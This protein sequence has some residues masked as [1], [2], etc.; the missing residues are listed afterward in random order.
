MGTLSEYLIRSSVWLT[1]FGLIYFLFLRDER[2]F[3]LNRIFLLTG[4][5]AS[6]CFPLIRVHYT[7]VIPIPVFETAAVSGSQPAIVPVSTEQHHEPN[8]L[9]CLYLSGILYLIFRLLKQTIRVVRVIRKSG[10]VLFNH[11]R[12]VR[13]DCYPAPFSFFKYVFVNPSV[14][15][16]EI[17]EIVHHE[18]EHIRQR[19]WIDLVLYELICALQWFNPAVWLYGRFIRQNHEYLADKSALKRSQDPGKYRA[20]LLN[21]MFGAPVIQLANSFCYSLNKKRFTMMKQTTISSPVRKLRLLWI[22]PLIAGIFYA[23]ATPEYQVVQAEETTGTQNIPKKVSNADPSFP[24]D[25]TL[26]SDR[27]IHKDD[28]INDR[29]RKEPSKI[30][31]AEEKQAN[32]STKKIVQGRVID[33]YGNPLEGVSV[34]VSRTNMTKTDADGNFELDMTDDDPVSFSHAGLR[35]TWRVMP[36]FEKSTTVKMK[37]EIQYLAVHVGM[38]VLRKSL[39]VTGDNSNN[40]AGEDKNEKIYAAVEQMPEFPGGVEALRRFIAK[41]IRYPKIAA[42]DRAQGQV[43]VSFVVNREGNIWNVKVDKS[44]H[45]ALDQEAIRVIYSLPQWKPGIHHE[46]PV[47]VAYKIPIS[48]SYEEIHK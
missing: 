10:S 37:S 41:G 5:I 1:G 18:Q 2:Y 9:F 47:N 16:A 43:F 30:K 14:S 8:L 44:V 42:E 35:T 39:A 36:D 6:V 12:L 22:L 4:M 46:K 13:A 34:V 19:H 7:Q 33:E 24:A 28:K 27:I 32:Q 40:N 11:I 38:T 31:R 25:D 29:E 48:F 15:E 17:S 3:T 45:P 23:F 20:A 21:Q 26:R